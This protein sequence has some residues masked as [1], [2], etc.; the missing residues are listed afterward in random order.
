LII[1]GTIQCLQ[2]PDTNPRSSIRKRMF[3][4]QFDMIS[5]N[6]W[7]TKIIVKLRSLQR[8]FSFKFEGLE[9]N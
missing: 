6:V 1:S 5:P 7:N 8:H 9:R 3:P 4:S 2:V